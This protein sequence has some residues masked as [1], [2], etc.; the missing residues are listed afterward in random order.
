MGQCSSGCSVVAGNPVL[1]CSNRLACNVPTS[2]VTCGGL[3]CGRA[4]SPWLGCCW[5]GCCWLCCRWLRCRWLGCCWL[6]RS[7]L[8]GQCRIRA[9]RGGCSLLLGRPACVL[10]A[11]ERLVHQRGRQLCHYQRLTWLHACAA[12]PPHQAHPWAR[13]PGICACSAARGQSLKL[14]RNLPIQQGGKEPH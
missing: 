3:G 9:G 14:A 6:G 13:L 10:M 7:R 1:H 2:P 11:C 4:P 12:P 5:L 8:I